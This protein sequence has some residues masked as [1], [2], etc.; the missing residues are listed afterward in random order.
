M[1]LPRSVP[2]CLLFVFASKIAFASSGGKSTGFTCNQVRE[3]FEGNFG[4]PEALHFHPQP[5]K[6]ESFCTVTEWI[7]S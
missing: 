6:S 1:A 3:L 7:E 4:S 2:V 5:G